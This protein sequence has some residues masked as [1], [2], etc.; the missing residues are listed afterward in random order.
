MNATLN[1]ER[2]L[3]ELDHAR[4]LKLAGRTGAPQ[5]DGILS[6]SDVVATRAVAADVVTMYTQVEIEDCHTRLRHQLVLCYPWD[7]EPAGG[8]IS[9]LSPVGLALLGMRAGSTV[10]WQ[11]PSGEESSAQVMS[12]LF[13]PE[14]SGDYTL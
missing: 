4:L 3:T 11:T 8:F 12:I 13:Q 6:G 14:A 2:T 10:R 5:L 1:G 7:A 9:V